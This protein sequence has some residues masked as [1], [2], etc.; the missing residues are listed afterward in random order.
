MRLT[1]KVKL[2]PTEQQYAA[3]LETLKTANAACNYI[4]Q[5]AWD[6]RT[7][8]QF[9]IHRLI[10]RTAREQFPLS[11]QMVVRAIAKVADAY[12]LDRQTKRTF[13]P[14]GGFAYDNRILSWKVDKQTVSIWTVEGRQTIPFLAGK[15]QLELLNAQRGES[16]L[17]LIDNEFYLFATCDV[18]EPTPDDVDEFMGVDLGVANIATT[19][20]GKQFAGNKVNSVRKRRRRQRKRLQKKGTKSAK[21]RLKKLSG[22]EQRFAKDVNHQISKQLVNIAKRTGRGIALED[23]Q[24]IRNRIRAGRNK[25]AELHSWSF[26]DLGQKI[27]YKAA[28][29]GVPVV[30][31][32]PA[33]T[34][35]KCSVCGYTAKHNRT[36]Q[37]NFK[38]RQCGHASNADV[39]A[40]VNI[41]RLGCLST[42]HTSQR[43]LLGTS[44]TASALGS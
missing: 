20:D 13:A 7:F 12:K 44:P 5:T 26:Y 18:D 28:L 25:R 38:C 16:D 23:L 19:S 6:D 1:A 2:Q 43:S 3:L 24:G 41:S 31:V 15:R 40:A 30:L 14:T 27:L 39:N 9:A 8:K 32:N 34:S 17:V 22:K 4:S 35:Q 33:Y 11:A 36:S 10:Y 29:T 42:T 37:S 21:R